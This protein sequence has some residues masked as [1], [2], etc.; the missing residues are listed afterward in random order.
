MVNF[1]KPLQHVEVGKG[2]KKEFQL[3]IDQVSI[4]MVG[5]AVFCTGSQMK[6]A[7]LKVLFN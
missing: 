7:I 2:D 5:V 3:N 4:E 6:V 1:F